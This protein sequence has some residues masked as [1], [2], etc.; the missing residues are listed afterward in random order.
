MTTPALSVPLT[1][2]VEDAAKVMA[3]RGCHH[4]V[5]VGGDGRAAGMISSL[6]LLRALVGL[7]A[8]F[9][10]TFPH[11]DGELD[12]TWTDRTL[13]DA[14][15]AGLTPEGAGVLV[16]SMGGVQRTECDLWVEA[17]DALRTR[18]LELVG[19]SRCEAPVLDRILERRDLRFRCASIADPKTRELVVA[20]LSA[21]IA[22]APRPRDGEVAREL[23][24]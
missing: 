8:K 21:R 2:S 19:G 9:P 15:H 16:L 11:H 24:R 7:P 3:E 13:F 5:V 17:S 6:D 14:D 20:K 1:M 22:W 12:V 18:V 23:P 4:L 10:S